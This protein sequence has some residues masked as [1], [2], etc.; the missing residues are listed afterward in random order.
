MSSPT[1]LDE[2]LVKRGLLVIL[3][4]GSFGGVITR[5]RQE[6]TPTKQLYDNSSVHLE[7]DQRTA[8]FPNRAL[9]SDEKE[10]RKNICCSRI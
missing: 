5:K 2:S 4:M 9:L 3:S 1:A 7:A 8:D 6:R 10:S